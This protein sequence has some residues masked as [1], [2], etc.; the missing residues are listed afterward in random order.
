MKYKRLIFGM[1][2]SFVLISCDCWVIVNGKVID[3][4]TKEPIEK[5]FLEFT[6]IRCTELVRATAQNVET[7]CVFATDS[8]GI[9]F[10]NS[11]SY[12][13]CPDNPV[14]IKIRKVGFKTVE[15]ELNQGH[16]IDDLIVKLEKE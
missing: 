3:S 5:A 2:I 4:N 7:N 9:F 13:F 1:L 15:L 14:K 6:N 8:T 11:D 12:G 10:M 16:S